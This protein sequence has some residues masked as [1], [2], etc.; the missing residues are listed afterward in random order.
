MTKEERPKQFSAFIHYLEGLLGDEEQ[1]KDKTALAEMRR[2]L[3]YQPQLAPN[4]HRYILPR[5]PE[6]VSSWEKQTYYI[7]ASLFAYYQAS[8][9]N[10]A[11]NRWHNMGSHFAA[12]LDLSS[13]ANNDGIER[14]F[15]ALLSAHPDDLHYQLR[16]SVAF[17]KSRQE[18]IPINWY[19]LMWDVYSWKH[20]ESRFK[21]QD[22]WATQFWRKQTQAQETA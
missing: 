13:E 12:A 8:M 22:K 16:Q 18:V 10:N 19:T 4:M 3:A 9:A 2:G 17:L 20:E 14:R 5:M 1:D 6:K 7:I 15:T 21:V 11:E